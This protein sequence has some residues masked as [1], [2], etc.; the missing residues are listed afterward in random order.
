VKNRSEKSHQETPQQ[1]GIT[2]TVGNLFFLRGQLTVEDAQRPAAEL[3]ADPIIESFA[4][5]LVD[6]SGSLPDTAPATPTVDVTLL[7]GVTDPVA[8]NLVRAAHLLGVETLEQA[9]TGQRYI[10]HDVHGQ[11]DPPALHRLALDVFSN[12]VIQRFAIDEPIRPPFVPYQRTDD[13]IDIIP[14]RAG[15][16]GDKDFAKTFTCPK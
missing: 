15:A 4:V 10:L 9:A 2:W 11:L 3:L 13:T 14:L 6:D 1:P 8:E 5:S 12:P 16:T 7:P